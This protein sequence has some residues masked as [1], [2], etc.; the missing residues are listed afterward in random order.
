MSDKAKEIAQDT[1]QNKTF[2]KNKKV[3][4]V[5]QNGTYVIYI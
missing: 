1:K 3:K 2:N 5:D 4:Y